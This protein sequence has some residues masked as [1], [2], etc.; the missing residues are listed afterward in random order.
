MHNRNSKEGVRRLQ[1]TRQHIIPRNK[2]SDDTES[3]TSSCQSHVR[4][5]IGCVARIEVCRSQADESYPHHEEQRAEC[6]CRF[7]CAQPEQEGEDEPGEDLL[8]VARLAWF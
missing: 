4:K 6:K 8:F 3:A 7:E 5:V 1:Q 2:R